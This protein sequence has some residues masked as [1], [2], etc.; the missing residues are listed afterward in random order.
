MADYMDPVNVK[1][2]GVD[3]RYANLAFTQRQNAQDYAG[4]MPDMAARGRNLIA[5]NTNDQLTAANRGIDKGA[6]ARGMYY[7]GSRLGK[8][9]Q[10]A[11]LAGQQV[12]QQTAK[13]QQGMSDTLQNLQNQ[14]IQSGF[15][16]AGV[17]QDIGDLYG[18][19]QYNSMADALAR[20][21][22]D[23]AAYKGAGQGIGAVA[24]SY[25][26]NRG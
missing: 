2:P 16:M 3:P 22:N 7:S 6:N 13:M 19:T 4:A 14:G 8:R 23:N 18:G 11:G 5:Q 17:S 26:G 10:A 9:A 12:G 21:Q 25:F 24:G 1:T 15:G 20:M